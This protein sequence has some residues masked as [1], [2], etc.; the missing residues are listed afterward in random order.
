MQQLALR[1][2]FPAGQDYAADGLVEIFRS[3]EQAPRCA[4]FV[5]GRR[6]L[7]KCALNGENAG[8][9]MRLVAAL[10]FFDVLD[11][12]NHVTRPSRP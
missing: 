10:L 5:K 11:R 9:V 8:D 4:Q 3:P 2:A 7:G 12:Y 1:G 6:M